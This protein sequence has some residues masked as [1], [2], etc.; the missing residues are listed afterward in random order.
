MNLLQNALKYTRPEGRINLRVEKHRRNIVIEISNTG[1]LIPAD[2][3]P[4][5]FDKYYRVEGKSQDVYRGTGLGLYFCRLVVEVHG[6]RIDIKSEA[7]TGTVVTI[8][9][10]DTPTKTLL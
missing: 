2:Q 3:L 8:R 4:Q 6:G 1:D 7:K 5:L 10:P 9:F